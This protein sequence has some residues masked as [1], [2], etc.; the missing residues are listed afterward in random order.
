[1]TPETKQYLLTAEAAVQRAKT[2][3]GRHEYNGTVH[4]YVTL[5]FI[6]QLLEHH[7]AALLLIKPRNAGHC[8]FAYTCGS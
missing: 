6:S 7:D 8:V 1:M 5:G 4:T 3:L 2:I